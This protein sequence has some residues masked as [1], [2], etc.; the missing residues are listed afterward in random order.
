MDFL[1]GIFGNIIQYIIYL[2]SCK[3]TNILFVCIWNL[4]RFI[5]GFFRFLFSQI[6][7]YTSDI[8]CSDDDMQR[9][10]CQRPIRW[11]GRHNNI[12]IFIAPPCRRHRNTLNSDFFPSLSFPSRILLYRFGGGGGLSGAASPPVSTEPFL[13]SAYDTE[14]LLINSDRVNRC[15]VKQERKKKKQSRKK[16][17]TASPPAKALSIYNILLYIIY[18]CVCRRNVYVYIIYIYIPIYIYRSRRRIIYRRNS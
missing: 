10:G 1:S 14:T 2:C 4:C 6:L 5:L 11:R 9:D 18:V 13:A 16:C 15:G 12:Y 17:L 3:E 8:N 7:C